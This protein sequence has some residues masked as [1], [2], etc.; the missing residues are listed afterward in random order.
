MFDLC[1][2]FLFLTL[3]FVDSLDTKL[4]SAMESNLTINNASN[5]NDPSTIPVSTSTSTTSAPTAT[6]STTAVPNPLLLPPGAYVVSYRTG[7]TI[8]LTADI[9]LPKKS[10]VVG[11]KEGVAL[12][13]ETATETETITAPPAS[14]SEVQVQLFIQNN[15]N[16]KITV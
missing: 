8:L 11:G 13:S 15:K 1:I 5:A 3:L 16:C 2:E 10:S 9:L 14:T 12:A 4:S 6:V 7:E